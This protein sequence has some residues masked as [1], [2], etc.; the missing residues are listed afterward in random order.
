MINEDKNELD[1]YEKNNEILDKMLLNIKNTDPKLYDEILKEFSSDKDVKQ[2]YVGELL[3]DDKRF[4]EFQKKVGIIQDIGVERGLG[5]T[6]YEKEVKNLMT[7]V[8]KDVKGAQEESRQMQ[9]E[10]N[11]LPLS[12]G[13]YVS[14][15]ENE[16][17]DMIDKKTDKDEGKGKSEEEKLKIKT[18]NKVFNAKIKKDVRKF[19]VDNKNNPKL[20][21]MD[22]LNKLKETFI[23]NFNKALP[24]DKKYSSKEVLAATRNSFKATENAI[25][26]LPEGQNQ[27]QGTVEKEKTWWETFKDTLKWLLEWLT[28]KDKDKENGRNINNNTQKK[29][30]GK[31]IKLPQVQQKQQSVVQKL[32]PEDLQKAES[33][34][35]NLSSNSG[36]LPDKVENPSL[37]P[38][39]QKKQPQK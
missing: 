23:E 1:V 16:L 20:M 36:E 5:S 7:D 39:L 12:V 13:I 2:Q 10:S 30:G 4:G 21:S 35:Q 31:E 3:M 18:R 29:C 8:K 27:G 38:D 11:R 25:E 17:N 6:D 19:V 22:N 34:I 14:R 15:L 9:K 26:K 32:N 24:G 28:E 37:V 33:L